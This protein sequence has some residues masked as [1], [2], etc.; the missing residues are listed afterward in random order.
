MLLLLGMQMECLS[1]SM[2]KRL[3]SLS[4]VNAPTQDQEFASSIHIRRPLLKLAL[5]LEM[6]GSLKVAL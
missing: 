4:A 2:V 6:D 3:A 5:G 1:G